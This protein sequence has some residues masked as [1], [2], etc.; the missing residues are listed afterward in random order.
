MKSSRKEARQ[1]LDNLSKSKFKQV[2]DE[3]KL[4][5]K[6]RDILILKH[7]NGFDNLRIGIEMSL[8]K[9]RISCELSKMY[10]RIAMIFMK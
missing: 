3:L 7:I 9:E 5:P 2:I 1:W 8:C 4:T 10:D 6:Q